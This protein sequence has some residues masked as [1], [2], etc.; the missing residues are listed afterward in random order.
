MHLCTLGRSYD[1]CQEGELRLANDS[2]AGVGGRVE[3]YLDDFWGT[4]CDDGWDMR[5][6][7]TVCRQ[8]GLSGRLI[9]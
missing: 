6:A 2:T 5:D 8:L 7:T 4:V 1:D 3:V 9:Q